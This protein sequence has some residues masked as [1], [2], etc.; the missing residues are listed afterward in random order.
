[1]KI[2]SYVEVITVANYNLK[3]ILTTMSM[4]TKVN[5]SVLSYIYSL[6]A[7]TLYRTECYKYGYQYTERPQVLSACVMHCCF[8]DRPS[9]L[10][11]NLLSAY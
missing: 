4:V 6:S 9:L 11:R 5:D 1:M 3:N 7:Y 8:V 10:L 2:H